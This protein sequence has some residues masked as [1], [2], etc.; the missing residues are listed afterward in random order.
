MRDFVNLLRRPLSD[1]PDPLPMQ[2][3][4][5]P[6]EMAQQ[7]PGSK[8]LT[9]RALVLAG[10]ASGA[11][12]L[13]N[14]LLGAEDSTVMIEALRRFGVHIH[15]DINA[16]GQSFLRVEGV[17]G[18]PSGAGSVHLANAGTAVRFLTAFAALGAGETIIDGSARMRERPIGGLV[19]ALRGLHVRV[20][21]EGE[22]GFPPI[23]VIPP[24]GGSQLLGG[25]L[26]LPEQA[27]SQFI[28]ALLMIAPWTR[29]GITIELDAPPLS[30]SYLHMTLTLLTRLGVAGIEFSP[31]FT[32]MHVPPNPVHAFDF[33]IEPDASG[34]TY[35][36]AA[37][38][39]TPGSSCSIRDIG[40]ESVQGDAQFAAALARMGAIADIDQNHIRIGSPPEG[41]LF[42]IQTDFSNM[43][44]AAMT[45]A[46]VAAF[47]PGRSVI[48]GLATLPFKECDRLKATMTE[49]RKLGIRVDTTAES[50]TIEGDP[51]AAT[52]DAPVTFDTYDD[53]RMAMA[54]ALIGLR[55]PNVFIE[56]PSCVAKTYPS[57]WRDLALMYDAA[58]AE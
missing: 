41:D 31:D 42:P 13:R 2:P 8:S 9:N 40:D 27:S 48:R 15:E 50:L 22:Y 14:P 52:R 23:R 1:M 7:P 43:P 39:M 28:S 17:N 54:L 30:A 6:F 53:H 24:R 12:V 4:P 33:L 29:D 34:A 3:M 37:A 36:W 45:L 49:L 35:F 32:S 26:H 16:N 20:E 44:D 10:L 11:S 21:F 38:A 25:E 47:V 57:F 19:A 55:R 5:R 51:A 58:L 46:A 56:N 18:V